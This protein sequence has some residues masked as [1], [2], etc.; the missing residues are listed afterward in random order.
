MQYWHKLLLDL[1]QTNKSRKCPRL[2]AYSVLT[3]TTWPW[4]PHHGMVWHIWWHGV[5][6]QTK[7]KNRQASL[8]LFHNFSVHLQFW[9]PNRLTTVSISILDTFPPF[10]YFCHFGFIYNILVQFYFYRSAFISLVTL[11]KPKQNCTRSGKQ[12]LED[13]AQGLK[14]FHTLIK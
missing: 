14:L 12:I 11:F 13:I 9:I 3:H 7:S 2:N 6:I 4:S 5:T 10:C 1:S 8:S